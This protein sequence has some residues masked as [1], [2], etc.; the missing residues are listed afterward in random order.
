[1]KRIFIAIM[2]VVGLFNTTP[3]SAE[4]SKVDGKSTLGSGWF[5]DLDSIRKVGDY[6][7]FWFLVSFDK[8]KP[9]NIWS[10]KGFIQTDC[11]L[12]RWKYL[13]MVYFHAPMGKG[14]QAPAVEDWIP[15]D[16]R[17]PQPD[18][19]IKVTLKKLVIM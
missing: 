15:N 9:M 14:E 3:A 1:M 5:I 4:W 6:I 17:Y 11:R 18:T 19:K 7:Y 16:W 2:F 13:E 10:S 12:L 8:S